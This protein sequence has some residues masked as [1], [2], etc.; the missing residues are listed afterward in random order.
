MISELLD[1][2]EIGILFESLFFEL[3]KRPRFP[4]PLRNVLNCSAYAV[5]RSYS[6]G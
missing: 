5:G 2:C 4:L 6:A 1:Y 3:Q